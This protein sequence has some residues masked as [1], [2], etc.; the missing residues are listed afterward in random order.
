MNSILKAVGA[1]LIAAALA[2]AGGCSSASK[3]VNPHAI[4]L[5]PMDP[6]VVA[7]GRTVKV[8]R[9]GDG[10]AVQWDALVSTAAGA[11]VVI[12][13]ENHGHKLGLAFA[14]DL[15]LDV[16]D[17]QGQAVLS[18][19][20]IDRD[21]QS[22][23]DD[24]LQGLWDENAFLKATRRISDDVYPPGHR[25]MVQ[26]AKA[27]GRPVIASN[28]PRPYVTAA[29]KDGY[30]RLTRLT[31]EEKRMFRI[32]DE[33]PTGKYRADFEK[34]MSDPAMAS[35]GDPTAKAKEESPE[36]KQKRLDAGFRAQS[37]WDWT[38]A[39]SIARAVDR[40]GKPVTHVVGRFH[41]DF[42][43]GLVQALNKLRPGTSIV[44]VSVVD[45]SSDTLRTED[46]DRG[47]F[48]VYVGT[49]P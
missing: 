46:K 37:L 47:T 39:D 35:H 5:T 38:M 15:W 23:L 49:E 9:G 4:S 45:A 2:V 32:P 48:V 29:R 3:P 28:A 1:S 20:F 19:E 25:A 42:N 18:M 10:A 44:T 6:A 21:D 13:G 41:C 17:R 30:E 34:V 14:S 31:A 40:D 33:L 24:Y 8:F 11:D 22:R 26:A 43:G 12:I 36:E 27:K 7:K 16:L